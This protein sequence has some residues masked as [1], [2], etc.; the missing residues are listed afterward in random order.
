MKIEKMES[1]YKEEE[2]PKEHTNY[3]WSS[4]VIV[5]SY[6]LYTPLREYGLKLLLDL[7]DFYT[8]IY[9]YKNFTMLTL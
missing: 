5:V 3:K 9:T 2:Y 8:E 1:T 6:V 7:I 4:H